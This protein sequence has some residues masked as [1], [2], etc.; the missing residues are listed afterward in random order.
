M[1]IMQPSTVSPFT[2]KCKPVSIQQ[3]FY[4]LK[5]VPCILPSFSPILPDIARYPN[6][7][8][9]VIPQIQSQNLWYFYPFSWCVEHVLQM[10]LL[11]GALL[12]TLGLMKAPTLVHF[13]LNVHQRCNKQKY[14]FHSLCILCCKSQGLNCRNVY[15]WDFFWKKI[16]LPNI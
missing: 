2:M 11:Q 1:H 6:H 3:I 14:I 13:S 12:A 10:V 4:A 7:H 9:S 15:I 5:C 16:P 8:I